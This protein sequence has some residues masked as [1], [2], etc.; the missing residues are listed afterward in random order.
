MARTSRIE[1]EIKNAISVVR[2]SKSRKR[3]IT[4]DELRDLMI[5]L[6]TGGTYRL[7]CDASGFPYKTLMEWFDDVDQKEEESEY[8]HVVKL[9]R[10]ARPKLAYKALE[11][12]EKAALRDWKAAAWQL[13]NLYP[14]DVG[15]RKAIEV[16]GP[17]GG[18]IEQ[19]STIEDAR[20]LL[21]KDLENL[22]DE[23]LQDII[24]VQGDE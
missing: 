13:T 12:I 1:R 14:E 24:D 2:K 4:E 10:K 3:K 5:V 16:S 7:A 18:P 20:E 15:P 11:I 19:Y 22:T 6:E 23:Q 17:N 8:Y 21:R 9:I